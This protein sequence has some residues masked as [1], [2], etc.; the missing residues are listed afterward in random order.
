MEQ[1]QVFELEVHSGTEDGTEGD[2]EYEQRSR[3]RMRE[4][5]TKYNSCQFRP[6]RIFERHSGCHNLAVL[7]RPQK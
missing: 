1:G 2:E 6:F 5:A 7:G 4:L 3:H